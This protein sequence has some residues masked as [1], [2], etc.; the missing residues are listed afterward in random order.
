MLQWWCKFRPQK[1]GMLYIALLLQNC[2]ASE[3]LC[4]LECIVNSEPKI[5]SGKFLACNLL[6][7]LSLSLSP[8][9][10][11]PDGGGGGSAAHIFLLSTS[12]L[13]A[14]APPWNDNIIAKR[15]KSEQNKRLGLHK[16]SSFY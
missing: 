13:P 11:P 8:P 5:K 3:F 12:L 10:F 7:S 6:N 1:L 9:V 15:N 2:I 16:V 14:V 4:M